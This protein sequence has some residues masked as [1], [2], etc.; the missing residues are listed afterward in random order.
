MARDFYFEPKTCVLRTLG[1]LRTDWINIKDPKVRH[2]V[3]VEAQYIAFHRFVLSNVRHVEQGTT[4]ADGILIGRSVRAGA[5]KALMLMAAAVCEAV[6]RYHAEQRGYPLPNQAQH[7]TYGKVL[8]AWKDASGNQRP[9]VAGMWPVLTSLRKHRNN[10]HLF[11]AA[12]DTQAEFEYINS[13]ESKILN[14]IDYTFPRL[15]ALTSP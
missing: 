5:L 14:G 6:L 1:E 3:A 8:D 7:R 9:E 2:V 10:V 12:A 13:A 4:L 11:S 15:Q